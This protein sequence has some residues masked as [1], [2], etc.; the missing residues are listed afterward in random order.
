MRN[1]CN[2]AFGEE[3][4]EYFEENVLRVFRNIIFGIFL[5]LPRCNWIGQI[6]KCLLMLEIQQ[7]NKDELHVWVQGEILKFTMLEFAIISGLKCTGNIDDYMY[8][9]SSKSVLMSRYFFNN[10]GAITHSKLITRVQNRNFD[11]AEDALN[12]T[13][14]F[15]VHTFM[16][17]QHKEAPISVAHFQIVEDGRYIHFP[18]GKVTFEKLMSF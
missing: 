6:S 12:L 15:F 3:I 10:I 9:S 14:L 5:D 4:K 7:D 2:C 1:L 11:N 8:A 16:F 17:Y 18:W 13:I